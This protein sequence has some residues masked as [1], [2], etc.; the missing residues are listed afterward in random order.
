MFE[1]CLVESRIENISPS[2]RWTA[3]FS[4]ALQI[5]VAAI[6]VVLPLLHPEQ[7][8]FRFDAPK[9]TLPLIKHLP[10]HVEVVSSKS[11]SL[12]PGNPQPLPQANARL[13]FHPESSAPSFVQPDLFRMSNSAPITNELPKSSAPSISVVQ[14]KHPSTPL[15][16]STG[17]AQGML[18]APIRPVY[19]PIAKAAHVEGEVVVDAVISRI[20]SVEQLEVV[21]GPPMLR[22]AALEA[23]R[24][25]RYHPY[26]LNGEATEVQITITVN[27]RIGA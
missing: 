15:R 26:R 9:V 6:I 12:V 16:V 8:A 4:I 20:G 10:Q 1:D 14:P 3:V 19:P 25:A 18:L 2:K 21:S 11:N 5:T 13:L 23:I 7:L 27:F 17:V 22:Q 24:A